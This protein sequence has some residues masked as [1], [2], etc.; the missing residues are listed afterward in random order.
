MPTATKHNEI[1]LHCVY[2]N[3]AGETSLSLSDL[4]RKMY[5]DNGSLA[6]NI[7]FFNAEFKKENWYD[8]IFPEIEIVKDMRHKLPE[9]H[10]SLF[11]TRTDGS[12]DFDVL[13]RQIKNALKDYFVCNWDSNAKKICFHSAGYDSRIISGILTELRQEKGDDWIGN[14]HF[15]CHQPEEIEFVEIMKLQG[16]RENQYSVWEKPPEDHYNIGRTTQILNGFLPLTHQMDF[17]SDIMPDNEKKNTILILG[18]NGGEFFSYH[19]TGRKRVKD[20]EYCQSPNMNRW[21]NYFSEEGEWM[22]MYVYEHKDVLAPFLS[23]DYLKLACLMSN[24]YL[25]P[26]TKML[27]TVRQAILQTMSINTLSVGY[28][29]HKY[30]WGIS[31]ETKKS[32]MGWYKKSKFYKDYAIEVNFDNIDNNIAGHDGRLWAFS[33]MYEKIFA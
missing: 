15:R 31:E 7:A 28:G 14:L 27:D 10:Q 4:A 5:L 30:T 20:I 19:A 2:T 29:F 21:L 8:T 3:K 24:K 17:A 1:Y 12:M 32:M 9:Q 16:W 25:Y 6:V 13:I 26:V 23:Y 33:L 22:S 11:S 18:S